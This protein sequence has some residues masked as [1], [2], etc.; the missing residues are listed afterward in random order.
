MFVFTSANCIKVRDVPINQDVWFY[1]DVFGFE[2][3][4]QYPCMN[5]FIEHSRFNKHSYG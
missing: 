4:G 3:Y 5:N 2:L 1:M